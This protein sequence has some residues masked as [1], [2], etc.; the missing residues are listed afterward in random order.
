[1]TWGKPQYKATDLMRVVDGMPEIRFRGG[2]A[3]PVG[4]GNSIGSI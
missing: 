2:M 3:V 4:I 1:M